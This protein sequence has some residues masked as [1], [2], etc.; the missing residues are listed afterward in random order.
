MS[1]VSDMEHEKVFVCDD[2]NST[3]IIRQGNTI[4]GLATKFICSPKIAELSYYK[5]TDEKETERF[6]H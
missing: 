5:E 4:R 1:L 3:L 2:C 6:I